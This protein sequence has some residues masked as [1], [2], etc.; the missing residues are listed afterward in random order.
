MGVFF[1]KFVKSHFCSK[2]NKII[3]SEISNPFEECAS[4]LYECRECKSVLEELPKPYKFTYQSKWFDFNIEGNTFKY[5]VIIAI[6]KSL[7]LLIGTFTLL[8]IVFGLISNLDI[9]FSE[10]GNSIKFFLPYWWL[11]GIGIFS[12]I[13]ILYKIIDFYLSSKK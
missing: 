8:L 2:C 3:A 11:R 10:I 6:P 7:F 12:A 4:N 9:L 5:W 1:T 13:Y